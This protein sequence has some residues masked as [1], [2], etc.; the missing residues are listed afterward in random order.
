M[1][2][3]G[4]C[5]RRAFVL[6][7]CAT[8]VAAIPI[9]TMMLRPPYANGELPGWKKFGKM[10]SDGCAIPNVCLFSRRHPRRQ[11][12]AAPLYAGFSPE[13]QICRVD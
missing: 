2:H 4:L 8:M 5:W 9:N 11:P 6:A 13:Y 1:V 12:A 10:R 7:T 3:S